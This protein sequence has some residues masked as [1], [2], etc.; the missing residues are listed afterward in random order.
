[1]TTIGV[2]IAEMP[3]DERTALLAELRRTGIDAYPS[4]A[5]LRRT[6]IDVARQIAITAETT[7]EIR[8]AYRSASAAVRVQKTAK[9]RK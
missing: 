3:L 6:S 5:V 9:R 1:M 8:E 2:D 7:D 4:D